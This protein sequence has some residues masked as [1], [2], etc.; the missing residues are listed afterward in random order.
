M[1]YRQYSDNIKLC[2]YLGKEPGGDFKELYDFITELWKDMEF[3]VI[4]AHNGQCIILHKGTEYYMEQE[5]KNGWLDCHFT[6]VWS[7]FRTTKGMGFNET[8]DFI[9]GMVEEHLKCNV[10]SL[11]LAAFDGKEQVE[12]HLNCQG[13]TPRLLHVRVTH[14]VEMHLKRKS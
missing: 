2:Q 9:R 6:R 11:T 3:S 7:F 10:S 5:F 13:L 4:D 14:E 8:R 12:E 1:T